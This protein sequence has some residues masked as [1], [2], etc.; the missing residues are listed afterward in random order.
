M[1]VRARFGKVVIRGRKI[2]WIFHG[3]EARAPAELTRS[4]VCNVGVRVNTVTC[5]VHASGSPV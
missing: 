3:S 2:E 1:G 4:R 5:I